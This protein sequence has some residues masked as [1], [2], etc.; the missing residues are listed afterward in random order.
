MTTTEMAGFH[1]Q[2][3]HLIALDT[4]EQNLLSA[5][6]LASDYGSETERILSPA[7]HGRKKNSSLENGVG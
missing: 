4:F 6:L 2:T 5:S 1:D 7:K 3:F